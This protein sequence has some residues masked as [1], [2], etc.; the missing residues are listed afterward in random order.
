[1]VAT[2]LHFDR[3]KGYGFLFETSGGNQYFFHVTSCNFIPEVG[4]QVQFEVGQGRKGV[5]AVN[6]RLQ[7]FSGL[8]AL[9]GGGN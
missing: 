8:G 3:G 7:N 6:V 1:M 9:A 5:A 2:I 4:Q